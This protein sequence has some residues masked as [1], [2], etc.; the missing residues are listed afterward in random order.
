[1]IRSSRP[2]LPLL[3][4]AGA[5]AV[6]AQPAF[7]IAGTVVSA[8][9]GAALARSHV[10]LLRTGSTQ[11]VANMITADD[12]KF[13]FDRPQGSYNLWAGNRMLPQA[14]G[15]HSPGDRISSS[16]ITGPGQDTSHLTLRYFA[17]VAISGKVVDDEGEPVENA[18]IQVVRSTVSGGRRSNINITWLRTNDLGEYRIGSL[19]AGTYYLA[20]TGEPWFA[21]ANGYVQFDQQNGPSAAFE[22]VYYPGAADPSRAAP[23]ILKPGDEARADFTLR[24]AAGATIAV[25]HDAPDNFR[26]I[27]SLIREGIAGRESFQ[28][29]QN[30]SGT[31]KPHRLTGVPPGHYTLRVRPSAGGPLMEAEREL[32]VNGSNISVDLSL[33]PTPQVSGTVEFPGGRPTGTLLVTLARTDGT[34]TFSAAVKPD[35][36]FNF[37]RLD[38]GQFQPGVTLSGQGGVY[39]AGVQAQGAPFR[40][41]VLDLTDGTTAQLR[42]AASQEMGRLKGF[43]LVDGKPAEGVLV[44]LTPTAET[45]DFVSYAFQTDTDGSFDWKFVR[46]GSYWLFA[47]TE[48]QIEYRSF[49][50]LKP[51]LAAAAAVRIEPHRVYEQNVPLSTP[52]AGK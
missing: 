31:L 4:I 47:T 33:R 8:E 1:M 3:I 17:H 44:V 12:G 48:T 20:A 11:I 10:Y 14:Y 35:G 13:S 37:A 25:N 49:A 46:P 30:F 21:K 41:G 26:G 38:S 50:A 52:A 7:R 19:A 27:I 36:T 24:L 43:A 6:Y 34:G 9:T 22:P 51:Y 40:D 42:I 23:L 5:F 15:L 2:L 32:D 29:S 16:I 39:A 28:D 45:K 18:L